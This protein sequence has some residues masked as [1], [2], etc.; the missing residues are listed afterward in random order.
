MSRGPGKRQREILG[1]LAEAP[2]FYLADL[3]LSGAPY[4]AAWRAAHALEAAGKASLLRY[5]CGQGKLLVCRPGQVPYGRRP[6]RVRGSAGEPDTQIGPQGWAPKA[7]DTTISGGAGVV[8][9]PH[10]GGVEGVPGRRG[11]AQDGVLAE[12]LGH[13]PANPQT[14]GGPGGQG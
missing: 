4:R 5:A 14:A 2:S 9:P 11:I 6:E 10:M 1:R 12:H 8:L 13:L 7:A 3:G